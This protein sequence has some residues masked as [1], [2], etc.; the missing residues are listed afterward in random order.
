M[1]PMELHNLK[2]PAGSK[3]SRKRVGRGPGSGMGK[4]SGRGHKGQGSRSGH[5]HR[6]GNEGGQWPLQRRLPK[7]GFTNIF[8]KVFQIVNIA[9][10]SKCEAN[11]IDAKTLV[12]A[13]GRFLRVSVR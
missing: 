8:R 2:P 1:T 5:T 10:L 9:D 4:T 12:E 6:F 7:V 13:G 11:E 3:K